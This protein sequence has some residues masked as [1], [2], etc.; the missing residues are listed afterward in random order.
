MLTDREQ[1]TLNFIAHYYIKE[2]RAPLLAEIAQGLG[3]QSKGVIHRYLSSLEDK[4]Y[5]E[6]NSKSRGIELVD[7]PDMDELPLLGRIAAGKPIEAIEDQQLVNFS[8]LLGGPNRYVLQVKGHSMID[9]GIRNGDLVVIES[10]N[11]AQ[12]NQIV[13]ALIDNENATLKRIQF[14]KK[15]TVR[16]IPENKN[17]QAKEY[18]AE[19]VTI[20][21]VL[22]GQ[23]RMYS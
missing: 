10:C 16:L 22:V 23:V 6:R 20:Q 18:A 8:H 14:P 7:K 2:H 1:D 9:E 3:I 17:M 5:I 11:T 15:N 4:G 13:V 21:G 19:R 12:K